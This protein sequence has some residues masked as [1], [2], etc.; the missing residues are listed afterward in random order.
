MRVFFF[1]GLL[2]IVISTMAI[3]LYKMLEIRNTYVHGDKI[4]EAISIY[5]PS[6]RRQYAPEAIT[7]ETDGNNTLDADTTNSFVI[8]VKRDINEDIAAWIR[9]P[10]TNIDFPVVHCQDN[11]F[12]LNH[13]IMKERAASGALFIDKGNTGRFDDFN[14]IIYGH[15]MKDRSMFGELDNFNNTIFFFNNPDGRLFLPDT[16]YILNVF[17]YLRVNEDDR[18][19]YGS[20]SGVD[21]D[22]FSEYIKANAINYRDTQLSGIDRIVTLSTCTNDYADTR[23]VVLAILNHID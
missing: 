17:A 20:I 12:Y 21:V 13:D 9:I 8:N 5:A 14:T 18:Y 22:E 11:S 19:I 23:M 1:R 16:T 10:N 7:E 3:G 6:E 15:N 2:V 4:T